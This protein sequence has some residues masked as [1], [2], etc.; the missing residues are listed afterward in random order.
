M[1]T[2]RG[3]LIDCWMGEKSFHPLPVHFWKQINRLLGE[4]ENLAY[5]SGPFWD[6]TH[7]RL[8]WAGNPLILF[9]STLRGKSIRC[10]VGRT[11]LLPLPVHFERRINFIDRWAGKPWFPHPVH[12]GRKINSFIGG[13]KNLDFLFR[14]TL[15]GRLTQCFW[16]GT[17]YKVH[18]I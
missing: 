17:P 13:P 7:G 1:S 11:T 9:Q 5:I 2:L 14:F 3:K 12:F 10:W 4:P 15:G 6:K 8:G 16:M 18:I